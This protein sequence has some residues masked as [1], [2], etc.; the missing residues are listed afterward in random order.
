MRTAAITTQLG[1]IMMRGGTFGIL[2]QDTITTQAQEN[3]Y[4]N[5]QLT[6][7]LHNT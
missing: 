7:G 4:M 3:T 6:A 1:T 2:T 5:M